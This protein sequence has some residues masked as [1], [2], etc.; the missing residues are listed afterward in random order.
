M[1]KRFEN[2]KFLFVRKNE[3]F[4]DAAQFVKWVRNNEEFSG[5]NVEFVQ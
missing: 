5:L 1:K 2:F 4:R 3:E